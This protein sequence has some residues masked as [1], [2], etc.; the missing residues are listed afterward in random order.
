MSI[1]IFKEEEIIQLCKADAELIT[2]ALHISEKLGILA[3]KDAI[4][5][6]KSILMVNKGS[7]VS[8]MDLDYRT[9][10]INLLKLSTESA[11]EEN[12]AIIFSEIVIPS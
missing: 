3:I 1:M 6:Y 7:I 11:S 4:N 5:N 8:N 10:I 2:M 12:K 9:Y